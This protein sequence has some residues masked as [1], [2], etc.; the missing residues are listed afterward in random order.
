MTTMMQG[1]S[2]PW[3]KIQ[4][5]GERDVVRQAALSLAADSYSLDLQGNPVPLTTQIEQL[6]AAIDVAVGD[7]LS[8]VLHDPEF[9]RTEAAWR[10]LHQLVMNTDTGAMLKLRVLN[11]RRAELRDDLAKAIDKDQSQL[12]KKLYEE[13]YGTFGGSA[14]SCLLYDQEF[15]RTPE[16]VDFLANLSGVA[17]AAHAP[18]M[19]AAS[20][21]LFDLPDDDFRGLGA[22]RDLSKIFESAEMIRW[23]SFRDSEDSRYVALVLPRVL[24]RLPYGART[25]PVEGMAFE[26]NV[27]ALAASQLYD[28]RP[29]PE[30]IAPVARL[31]EHRSYLWGNAVWSLGQR[32]TEAFALYGWCAA[33]RGVEG[34]GVVANLPLHTFKTPDG[35]TVGKIP[36]ETT[37]TDRR[38]KELNDLGFI[39]LCYCKGTDYACFFGGA[40]AQKPRVYTVPEA[41]QNAQAS[42]LLPYVLAASRFA[43]YIKKIGREKVGS[44][45]TRGTLEKYLNNWIADYVLLNDDAPQ[46]AKARFPL[47]EA[48]IDVTE[49][50][51]KVGAYNATV[52]LRPHFQL[53]EL[54]ASIRLVAHIPP[55]AA[56]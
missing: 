43:H 12:F 56:A 32:I 23:K 39:S 47:R 44:F 5:P 1:L 10:G 6:I 33:I 31:K 40:T 24:M 49:V 34:G 20:P 7:L 41:S 26:E 8:Q 53:E 37:I 4:N 48:R 38:E 42:A 52:F 13:E 9:Q 50:P 25:N 11:V 30:G 35:E 55:P 22:P 21:R 36:T 45:Q 51:G 46:S 29:L 18:L 27:E 15:G 19:T 28:F 14:F 3:L 2:V 17:A 54:T 16:D